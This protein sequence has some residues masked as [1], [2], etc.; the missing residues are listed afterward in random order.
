MKPTIKV[1]GGNV[2]LMIKKKQIRKTEIQILFLIHFITGIKFFIIN[3]IIFNMM[4]SKSSH[5]T[6]TITQY[7]QITKC[8]VTVVPLYH[9]YF[10]LYQV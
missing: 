6:Q 4:L 7:M 10:P 9:F 2:E 1:S 5:T 3:E 8:I